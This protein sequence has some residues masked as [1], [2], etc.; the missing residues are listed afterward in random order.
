MS[1]EAN[2]LAPFPGEN[3]GGANGNVMTLNEINISHHEKP[4]YRA[5]WFNG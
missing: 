5:R 4:R 2:F 3:P 1:L